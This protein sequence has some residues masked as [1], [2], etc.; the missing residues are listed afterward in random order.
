MT[1]QSE[2]ALASVK[3][4]LDVAIMKGGIFANMEGVIDATNAYNHIAT[5]CEE[6]DTLM[7]AKRH[8]APTPTATKEIS[9]NHK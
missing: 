9:E 1:R 7:V 8:D 4:L 3:R 2:A 6:H 5:V